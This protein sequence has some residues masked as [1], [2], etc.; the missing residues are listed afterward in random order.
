MLDKIKALL[1]KVNFFTDG[2]QL[3]NVIK[4][5]VNNQLRIAKDIYIYIRF[6]L[7]MRMNMLRQRNNK[8]I[9]RLKS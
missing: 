8:I 7:V 6:I 1:E 3:Y 2:H 4:C 5:K 9:T